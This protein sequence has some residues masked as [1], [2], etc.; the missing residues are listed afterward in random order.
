MLAPFKRLKRVDD[1]ALDDCSLILQ[2]FQANTTLQL[3][4]DSNVSTSW[5]LGKRHIFL[6]EGAR[7]QLEAL[8]AETRHN[9]AVSIQSTWRG[10]HFRRRWPT[11][12]RQLEL[13]MGRNA[14]NSSMSVNN[15]GNLQN[16]QVSGGASH[17]NLNRG[18]LSNSMILNLERVFILRCPLSQQA[19][20]I[21]LIAI[22]NNN[23]NNSS[24]SNRNNSNNNRSRANS[25][26][27]SAKTSAHRNSNNSRT[28]DLDLNLSLALLRRK[29]WQDSTKRNATLK[30]FST[31]APFSAW[32]WWVYYS[33]ISE[34][35]LGEKNEKEII[36][37]VNQMK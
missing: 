17:V 5:S 22:N 34:L 4:K 37:V 14:N 33:E 28:E 15:A 30:L 8:R 31:R 27:V 36:T 24:C 32:T 11:V 13:R 20:L 12:K 7:Q 6:S 29:L 35:L 19:T 3:P 25:C 26:R 1:K 9:A 23:L 10:W 16:H 18:N 2:S 21:R